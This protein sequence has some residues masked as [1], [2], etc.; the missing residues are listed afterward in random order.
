MTDTPPVPLAWI[1]RAVVMIAI[2]GMG[3]QGPAA[4][5]Q[6]GCG[7]GVFGCASNPAERARLRMQLET[8]IQQRQFS[9]RQR[10]LEQ[11]ERDRTR[12]DQLGQQPAGLPG[13][14]A[15]M[16]RQRQA[17]ALREDID[18]QTAATRGLYHA[19]PLGPGTWSIQNP[20]GVPQATCRE[21]GR[22]LVC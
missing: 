9:A 7:P 14:P 3:A 11:V 22:V 12:L 13:S 5:A 10:G 1:L 17:Q 19:Q 8:E 21:V 18:R 4:R 6:V 15:E 20:Q 16:E 2:C